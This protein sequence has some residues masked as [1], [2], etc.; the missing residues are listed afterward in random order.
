M[1]RSALQSLVKLVLVIQLATVCFSATTTWIP[2]AIEWSS[3]FAE[4][5]IVS[6]WNFTV[7][8][9]SNGIIHE[10]DTKGHFRLQIRTTN[11][12]GIERT[13]STSCI[14]VAS[15][16]RSVMNTVKSSLLYY[17]EGALTGEVDTEL[18]VTVGSLF[19]VTSKR[20]YDVGNNMKDY[21]TSFEI[22]FVNSRNMSSLNVSIDYDDCAPIRTVGQWEDSFNWDTGAVPSSAD[23]VIFGA[24]AGVAKINAD[25]AIQSLAMTGGWIIGHDT[26]CPQ[27]WAVEPR[28]THGSKC[29]RLVETPLPFQQAER[30]CNAEEGKGSVNRHLVHIRDREEL[31]NVMRLCRGQPGTEVYNKGCWIGLQDVDGDGDFDWIQPRAVGQPRVVTRFGSLNTSTFDLAGA[32]NGMFLDWRRQEP[33]NHTL[34]EG[35]PSQEG[36]ERCGALIAWQHD[37]LIQE[38]GSWNDDACQVQRPFVCQ[39]FGETIRHTV[40]VAGGT[41][42]DGDARMEGGRL[43]TGTGV[44]VFTQFA[45]WR[46]AS[47][48]FHAGAPICLVGNISITD[49]ASLYFAS[50]ASTLDNAFIGEHY[51]QTAD[52][53][54]LSLTMRPE[55]VLAAGT[56]F[57]L[58]PFSAS[59]ANITVNVR[60]VAFG[61]IEVGADTQAAFLQG[62]EL[63]ESTITVAGASSKLSLGGDSSRLSTYD[64][65]Q[66][67]VS[68]RGEF[69][70]E[71]STNFTQEEVNL[72][73]GVEKGVYRL[74]VTASAVS[75]APTQTTRCIPYNATADMLQGI[76]DELS[77]VSDRGGVT[78]RRYGQGNSSR[79]HFGYT[80]RIEM[81]GPAT[82]DFSDGALDMSIPCYGLNDACDCAETKVRMVD[83]TGMPMCPRGANYSLSDFSTCVIDPILTV[84]PLTRLA[85]AATSG[86]GTI[87]F[88]D[89]VHR[90]PPLSDCTLAVV[91]AG[92]GVVGADYIDWFG[93]DVGAQGVLV[94]A[95]TGW[96]AWDSSYLLYAPEWTYKRGFV[97]TLSAAPPFTMHATYFNIDGSGSVLAACPQSN[98]TWLNGS[99]GGGV[100]GGR[101]TLSLTGHMSAFAGNK[102]L[103]FAMTLFVAETAT[104]EWTSGNLSLADGADL[105]VE[106]TLRINTASSGTQVFVG[107]AQLLEAPAG[108]ETAAALLD[109]T[110]GRNWHS[111]YGDELPAEL[112][113]GWYQNPLCG[114]QCLATNHL[115]VQ[116]S[117]I[118]E[119]TSTT[120]VQFSL[121]LDLV[122]QSR[123]NIGNNVTMRIASGGICGNDV[124]IDISSGTELELSGGQ[125]LMQATCTIQGEGEL[126]VTA[127]SHDLSFS[128]DAHITIQGGAMVWPK[129]RGDGK[130]ISFNGGLLIENTGVLEVNAFST[131]ILVHNGVH[132]REQS[133]IQFPLIGIAAQA[134]LFD[135]QDAPDPS[136]RGNLTSTARMKW[137]GG[138]IK[139][140]ADINALD[141]LFL[142]GDTKYL[143]S[144]AKLVNRGHCEWGTGDLVSEDSGDFLNQGTVQM[145]EGVDGFASNALYQGTELPVDSGGDVFALEYHSWDMDNGG[146][147]YTEYVRQRTEFV[148]RAPNGWTI[149]SQNIDSSSSSSSTRRRRRRR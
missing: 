69:V 122:G 24:L 148:S 38:Q 3:Q 87:E 22:L 108:D 112:R 12:N 129:S 125:M 35:L 142:D 111:Y 26:Y 71:Y 31:E 2:D 126:L 76:L 53:A 23:D 21:R 114:G 105:V 81:D 33:N 84:R 95:G 11:R 58:S 9:N 135:E 143:K 64:A 18:N 51:P 4:S 32:D 123:M 14:N 96:V 131:T 34:S 10:E 120:S 117:G 40:T 89:G 139:G 80:Y 45:L 70:G 42:L 65:Y 101:A 104:M 57:T 134:S 147:D 110:Q 149:A 146:L 44:G 77:L 47:V 68:H 37:P 50:D 49:G 145:M 60:V 86:S 61:T 130:A 137:D 85:H 97:S 107:M 72:H 78:V 92:L 124:I 90:L 113:T 127:G 82:A 28:G 141:S 140:K 103:R 6:G 52:T 43:L 1:T 55:V 93:F 88:T 27:G 121:P 118:V 39:M 56:T 7:N 83:P 19:K 132:L 73:Q 41:S 102:A 144:L 100:I 94:L 115:V 13:G 48:E 75:G 5:P 63:S 29:Y 17:T 20:Y 46:S 66:L 119:S 25:V 136:P 54:S 106:G 67:Q 138:T 15:A 99:W 16:S 91:G 59:E 36:G 30:T 62:A 116:A 109:M 8:V 133:L 74:Q 79:F 128:I 98:L